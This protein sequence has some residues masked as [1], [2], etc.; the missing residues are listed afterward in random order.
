VGVRWRVYALIAG[1][2]LC[3]NA[4]HAAEFEI[5]HLERLSQLSVGPA[6]SKASSVRSLKPADDSLLSFT[7]FGRVFKVRL[8]RNGALLRRLPPNALLS[9]RDVTVLEGELVDVPGSWA[10]ITRHGAEITGVIWDGVELFAIDSPLRLAPFL[11]GREPPPPAGPVIYRWRDTT[12]ALTDELAAVVDGGFDGSVAAA[13]AAVMEAALASG[14]QLDLGLVADTELSAREGVNVT[15]NMLSRANIVDGIYMEQ[16]GV[17]VNV[18]ELKAFTQ[19]QD[20]FTSSVPSVLLNELA[21]HRE[22]TP[23][24][25]AQDLTHLLTGKDLEGSTVGLA[26]LRSVCDA[27]LGA[28]LTQAGFGIV[29]D[30]LIMAHEIGHNFGAPHDGEPGP[31]QTEPVSGYIMA[32]NAGSG[33]RFSACSIQQ[34][35]PALSASCLDL[36]APGDVELRTLTVPPDALIGQEF[37]ATFALDNPS[38]V[39]AYYTEVTASGSNL[40]VKQITSPSTEGFVCAPL[41][42]RRN[43]LPAGGSATFRV[44]AYTTAIASATLQLTATT[45]NDANT[46]NNVVSHVLAARPMVD[47]LVEFAPTSDIAAPGQSVEYRATVTNFGNTPATHAVARIEKVNVALNVVALSSAL[48]PC[49]P[50]AFERYFCPL[51]D[52]APGASQ[53]LTLRYRATDSFPPHLTQGFAE[54]TVSI[55]ATSDQEVYDRV[56]STESL[57]VTVT[58]SVADLSISAAPLQFELGSVAE[59]TFTIQNLG[60]DSAREVRFQHNPIKVEQGFTDVVLSSNVG[61]CTVSDLAKLVFECRVQ[62]LPVGQSLTITLHGTASERGGFRTQGYLDAFGFDRVFFNN[63][64]D[65]SYSINITPPPTVTPPPSA[66]PPST[67]PPPAPTA[68]G[69]GG[70]GGGAFDVYCLTL[71]LLSLVARLATARA[72]RPQIPGC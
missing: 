25:R 46:A 45:L 50:D 58:D 62:T 35:Q 28:G 20:P 31:C 22:G 19:E 49:V 71:L 40:V 67:A 54:S 41:V 51:G 5:L 65:T 12:G 48:G 21:A 59:L 15:A 11:K 13:P 63:V 52:L 2:L 10:R 42:C 57:Y 38:T 16:L 39:D 7:A 6:T 69:G 17:H 36:I 37:E 26:N 44:V 32:K 18:A 24:Q 60:P 66:S 55:E 64:W 33:S 14:R 1:V 43:V 53:T 61:D 8:A 23:E 56:R 47:L 3:A 9:V 72:R 4:S 29:A 34:M 30:A 68:S 27:R 70:G